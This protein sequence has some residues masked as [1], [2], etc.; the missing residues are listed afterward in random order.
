MRQILGLVVPPKNGSIEMLKPQHPLIQALQSAH[1]SEKKGTR[2]KQSLLL[3]RSGSIRKGI[4][5]P[6]SEHQNLGPVPT[7]VPV[8][9]QNEIVWQKTDFSGPQ[10]SP[11]LNRSRSYQSRV[12]P[13]RLCEIHYLISGFAGCQRSPRVRQSSSQGRGSHSSGLR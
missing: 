13:P 1:T 3:G 6:R 8:L 9:G 7:L 4:L 12:L 2:G 11:L 5:V 10:L